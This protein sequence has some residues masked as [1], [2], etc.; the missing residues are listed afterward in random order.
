MVWDPSC[1]PIQNVRRMHSETGS[2]GFRLSSRLHCSWCLNLSS[3]LLSNSIDELLGAQ[4]ELPWY[5]SNSNIFMLTKTSKVKQHGRDKPQ[6]RPH[7]CKQIRLFSPKP[8]KIAGYYPMTN[9]RHGYILVI[10]YAFKHTKKLV[11][12][13]LL[14]NS[15]IVTMVLQLLA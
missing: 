11:S 8:G 9:H 7:C 10:Y 2:L 5:P 13:L 1:L 12:S 6:N 15:E 4:V 14:R 3:Q